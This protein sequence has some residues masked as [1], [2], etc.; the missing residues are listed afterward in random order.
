MCFSK[1]RSSF[2]EEAVV[3]TYMTRHCKFSAYAEGN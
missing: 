3:T 2:D 1:K